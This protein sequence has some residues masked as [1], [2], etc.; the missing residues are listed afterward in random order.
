MVQGRLH[1]SPSMS[2]PH[3]QCT[4]S[5]GLFLLSSDHWA[6]SPIRVN[7]TQFFLFQECQEFNPL[8]GGNEKSGEVKN[9]PSNKGQ[10]Q[11]ESECE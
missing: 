9:K 7:V 11:E 1:S 10:E 8:I 4:F 2:F 6:F 5:A 3:H